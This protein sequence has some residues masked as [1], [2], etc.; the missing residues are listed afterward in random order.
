M[1]YYAK[2]LD[3]KVVQV[4]VAES[5]FFN[6]FVDS[7]PGTWLPTD[8]NGISPLNYAGIGYTW[9]PTLNGFIAPQ[10]FPSWVL[11]NTTCQYNAPT[12]MPADGQSYQWDEPSLSWVLR[13]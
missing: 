1:S 2:V 6:T 10:P 13:T 12:S 8:I 7:S 11:N 5:D 9:N 4:I 3:G